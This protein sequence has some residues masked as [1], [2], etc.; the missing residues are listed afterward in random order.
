MTF[1]SRIV[2]APSASLVPR[3]TYGHH[4]EIWR[5]FE[6]DAAAT[7][8]F[9]YRYDLDARGPRYYTVSRRE[10]RIERSGWVVET[11]PYEPRLEKGARLRFSLRAN[12]TKRVALP[13]ERS[14][15][16]RHDVVMARKRELRDRGEEAPHAAIVQ[17]AGSAWLARRAESIGA[18]F[19]AEELRIEGYRSHRFQTPDGREIA[20]SGIDYDGLLTVTDP[21][22][23]SQVL[24]KG[25]GPAKGFGFGLLLVKR[26]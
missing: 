2:P 12:P 22:R 7:R 21:A 15:G 4:Q 20:I 18:S 26:P 24:M 1:L 6:R 19:E 9:L 10:P 14:D 5:F 11:R 13:G 8:D 16:A 25:V 23:F 17:E 3:G